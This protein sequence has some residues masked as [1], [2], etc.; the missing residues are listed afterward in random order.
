MQLYPHLENRTVCEQKTRHNYRQNL[1][2]NFIC[3]GLPFCVQELQEQECSWVKVEGNSHENYLSNLFYHSIFTCIIEIHLK[4]PRDLSLG[5]ELLCSDFLFKLDL[6]FESFT[7]NCFLLFT[8]V[9]FTQCLKT[10]SLDPGCDR[11]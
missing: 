10:L 11:M 8:Q 9:F 7:Q 6:P 4:P 2:Y 1:S 5:I 3:Y